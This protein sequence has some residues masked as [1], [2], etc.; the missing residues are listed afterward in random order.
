MREV[1][2]LPGSRRPYCLEFPATT[3]GG[4]DLRD[5]RPTQG[6][7]STEYVV[8]DSFVHALPD[9]LDQ[10]AVAPLMCAGVTVWSPLR[11]PRRLPLPLRPRSRQDGRLGTGVGECPANGSGS[12][13][14]A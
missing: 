11:A 13:W 10:A 7:Y 14:S 3:Y 1:R 9:G 6:A 8:R 2:E 5:G 12:G 4:R